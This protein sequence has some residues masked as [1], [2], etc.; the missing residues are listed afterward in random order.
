[1]VDRKTSWIKFV[2]RV[3]AVDYKSTLEPSRERSV[4]APIL[5]LYHERA[6]S[7]DFTAA[8][9]RLLIEDDRHA[10]Q[11]SVPLAFNLLSVLHSVY[12]IAQGR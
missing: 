6:K 12:S 1:M 4:L 9:A 11:N 2:R 10:P 8:I 5:C 3:W 7:R